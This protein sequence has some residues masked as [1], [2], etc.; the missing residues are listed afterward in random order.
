MV[1]IGCLG[2]GSIKLYETGRDTRCLRLCRLQLSAL[3]IAAWRCSRLPAGSAF[4][5]LGPVSPLGFGHELATPNPCKAQSDTKSAV[6]PVAVAVS[7]AGPMV[8]VL[9]A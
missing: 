1:G 4:L 5:L 9:A 6:Q 2:C 8:L 7:L 3:G